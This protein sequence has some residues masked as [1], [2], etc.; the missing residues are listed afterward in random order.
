MIKQSNVAGTFYPEQK[1]Q[2]ITL[3]DG[4]FKNIKTEKKEIPLK[5]IVAPHA[6]YIYSG[7]VAAHSYQAIKDNRETLPK[8][9]VIMAPSH[10]EYF[11]GISI[12]LYDKFETPLGTV[13]VDKK[14]WNTLIKEYPDIF[15]FIP[16]AYEQEHAL[17]VQLPFLQ[18]VATWPYKILPLVFWKVNP[19]EVGKILFELTKKENIFLIVSSDLSHFMDYDN[20]VQ[21]DQDTLD[22]FIEKDIEKIVNEAEACGIHPRLTLTQIAIQAKRTPKLLHYMNSGNTTWDKSRVVGYWSVIYY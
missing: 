22:D 3:L 21:T 20:A 9:F 10:Y 19:I 17:E 15:S 8:T 7:Q 18:Y 11:N 16:A 1:D 4:F 12:W 5:A 6:W 13:P 2:I 14:L